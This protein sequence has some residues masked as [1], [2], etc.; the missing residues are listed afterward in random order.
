MATVVRIADKLYV[1][2]V[3][4]GLV[5]SI[6]LA[7]VCNPDTLG[8]LNNPE[9]FIMPAEGDDVTSYYENYLRRSL[10]A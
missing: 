8:A 10:D 4:E 7:E 1:R 3:T 5:E 6:P 2:V 9:E